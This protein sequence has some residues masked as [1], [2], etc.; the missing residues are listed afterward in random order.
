MN[1]KTKKIIKIVGIILIMVAFLSLNVVYAATKGTIHF[2]DYAGTRRTLKIVGIFIDIIKIVVPL[3]II[4]TEIISLTKV[5]VSGK[6][7]DL[8]ENWKVFVRKVIAGLVI[9]IIPTVVNYAI[10]N[11]V[12]NK[13]AGFAQCST[14]MLDH[15]NCKIPDKDPEI[16]QED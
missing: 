14:C 2:C 12:G 8:K 5:M 11:L 1:E 10:N 16:Y 15:K 13:D 9:F 6:D 7:D 4:I 3:I